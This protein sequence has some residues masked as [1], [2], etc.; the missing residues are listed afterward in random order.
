MSITVSAHKAFGFTRSMVALT[1]PSSLASIL[2]QLIHEALRAHNKE[3]M[4]KNYERDS[5]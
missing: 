2:S 4:R 1:G 5:R 3:M